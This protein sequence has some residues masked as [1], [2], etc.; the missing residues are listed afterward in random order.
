MNDKE[1]ENKLWTWFSLSY[2][3]WLTLPRVLMHEMPDEWQG[4]MADLLEE[5]E[6]HW[7]FSDVDLEPSVQLKANGKFVKTPEWLWN[8]RHPNKAELKSLRKAQEK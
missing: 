1:G 8:Y 2:S 4:K 5:W 6:T 3:S 7:D